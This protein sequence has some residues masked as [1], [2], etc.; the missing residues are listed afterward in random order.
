VRLQLAATVERVPLILQS[1]PDVWTLVPD[2][3]RLRNPVARPMIRMGQLR[4]VQRAAYFRPSGR[5]RVFIVDGA[6]TMRWSDA[7]VFLTN[8][9]PPV[10]RKLNFDVVS[11]TNKPAW[12]ALTSLTTPQQLLFGS[13]IPYMTIEGTVTE[14]AQM[15]LSAAEI[16]AVE[17]DNAV[18]LMPS[19]AMVPAR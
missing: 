2:P 12:A 7:D 14:L 6:E 10:L 1:H 15:G 11:V 4:A 18:K 9:T 13:D 16:R 3:V 8:K 19:L 5:R 17:C